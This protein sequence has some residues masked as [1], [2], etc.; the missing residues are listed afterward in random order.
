MVSL[1]SLACMS[2]ESF[3]GKKQIFLGTRRRVLPHH[4]FG[5][6]VGL[7]DPVIAQ[8]LQLRQPIAVA[9]QLAPRHRTMASLDMRQDDQS[10]VDLDVAARLDLQTE[11]ARYLDPSIVCRGMPNRPVKDDSTTAFWLEHFDVARTRLI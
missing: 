9:R 8:G 2:D 4:D 7:H 5:N 10:G 1:V 3:I 11:Q 6:E